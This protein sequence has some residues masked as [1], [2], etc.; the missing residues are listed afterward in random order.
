[1]RALLD[2]FFG[3]FNCLTF[4][5]DLEKNEIYYY[6]SLPQIYDLICH[7]D[8]KYYEECL[9]KKLFNLM[10]DIAIQM[11]ETLELTDNRREYLQESTLKELPQ[12]YL[13]VDNG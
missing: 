12:P 2:T 4:S 13:H 5:Q 8:P 3:I 11:H 6:S 9:C 10:P 1:M 7:L